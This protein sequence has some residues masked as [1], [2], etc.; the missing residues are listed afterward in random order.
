MAVKMER[1]RERGK[2]I[3]IGLH[4]SRQFLELVILTKKH[5]NYIEHC[6]VRMVDISHGLVTD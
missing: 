1:E 4:I 3:D 6:N 5:M 2:S